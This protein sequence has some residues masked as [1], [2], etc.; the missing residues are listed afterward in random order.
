MICWSSYIQEVRQRRRLKKLLK[1]EAEALANAK[2]GEQVMN[3]K[4]L[5]IMQITLP[6]QVS[7]ANAGQSS[8]KEQPQIAFL[9]SSIK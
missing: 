1:E 2:G 7:F 3:F 8:S 4:D 9:V 5:E 6:P